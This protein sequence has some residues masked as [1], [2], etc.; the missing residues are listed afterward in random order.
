MIM[1]PRLFILFYYLLLYIHIYIYICIYLTD[2][3]IV[4]WRAFTS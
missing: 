4:P 2:I 1:Q 3:S